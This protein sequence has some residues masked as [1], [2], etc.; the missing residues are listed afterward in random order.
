MRT[1]PSSHRPSNSLRP[2]SKKQRKSAARAASIARWKRPVNGACVID[3][4]CL[5]KG[6]QVVSKHSAS[7]Q[8][9]CLVTREVQRE[10]LASVLEVRC[11]SCEKTF[12]IES[13]PKI[14]GSS[15]LNQRFSV[16]VGAVWG[17][18]AT[19]GGQTT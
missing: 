8:G 4:Q 15:K 18:M 6:I 5:S 2:V 14:S 7:C 12:L 10:G 13:S 11:S 3:L 17:Q 1:G 19:G 9:E 16:N